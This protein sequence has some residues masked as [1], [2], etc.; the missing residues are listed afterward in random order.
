MA[1]S[2]TD[3]AAAACGS[4]V[5]RFCNRC[6]KLTTGNPL[7]CTFCGSTY[8]V[9]LCARMHPN[10]RHA[11]V[12][13]QCGS[14]DMTTPQPR[15]PVLLRL[16]VFLLEQTPRALLVVLAG[17]LALLFLQWLFTDRAGQQYL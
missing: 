11:V 9:K 14:R 17:G 16:P 4:F 12:C 10:P 13:P 2:E 8:D 6:R 5:M 1:P 15:I 7:F 3:R